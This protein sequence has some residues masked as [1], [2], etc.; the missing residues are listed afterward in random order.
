MKRLVVCCDG[1]WNRLARP[2]PTNVVR[3]AEAVLPTA[4]D[5]TKQLIYYDEGVGTGIVG[6][7]HRINR[8]LS[9]AFGW[10]LLQ[11]VE[12]AY[13]FLV[14]NY[15]P[16]DE[17]FILGFS[18]GAFTARSLAGLIRNCGIVVQSNAHLLKDVVE[19][20][21]SRDPEDHPDSEKSRELRLRLSPHLYLNDAELKWRKERGT[22]FDPDA[23]SL[24]RIGYVGAWDTVG[25]LGIPKAMLFANLFNRQY[26]FH[27]TNLSSS[28]L[29]AR[30][31]VAIDERRR[32]FEPALWSN[33]DTL[34]CRAEER[35]G[36]A[37]SPEDEPFQQLWFPGDHSSVGGG[38][39]V[40][41]L[42]RA[43]LDWI[44]DGAE[45]AGLG[46]DQGILYL[47]RQAIDHLAGV[48]SHGRPPAWFYRK[49]D[50]RGPDR[51]EDVAAITVNRWIDDPNY[52]P[53]TLAKVKPRLEEL[54]RG[55]DKATDT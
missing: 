24:L 31:A 19:H 10:G 18:R 6:L 16:G 29:A 47:Y 17:I 42:A 20:Y 33:L 52:R 41:G 4:E 35:R 27:D 23:A 51:I 39:T 55:N 14:F 40:E 32:T 28:V 54:A 30:H 3:L 37:K 2:H 25:A 7:L 43:A 11:N 45:H 21:R 1:T 12:E 38:G 5:G 36:K 9:G 13:R 22:D 26:R 49:R 15:E 34:N 8:L 50:R 46:F 53:K 48:L 44:V